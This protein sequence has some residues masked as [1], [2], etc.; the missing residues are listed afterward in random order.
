MKILRHS[1]TKNYLEDSIQPHLF[2]YLL[3]N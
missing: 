2:I 1:L 3:M